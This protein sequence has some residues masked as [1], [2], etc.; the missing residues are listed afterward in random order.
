[1]VDGVLDEKIIRAALSQHLPTTN[2]E[3]Y[4]H[5]GDGDKKVLLTSIVR[6]IEQGALSRMW[7][8]QRDVTELRKAEEEHDNLQRQ[9]IQVQKMDSVGQLAGGIAHDFNNILVAILGYTELAQG[10]DEEASMPEPMSTYHREIGQSGCC[11]DT[12]ITSL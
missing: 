4:M 6:T 2:I 5:V 3:T 12:A 11:V 7:I 8:T 9:L 1:M 10:L